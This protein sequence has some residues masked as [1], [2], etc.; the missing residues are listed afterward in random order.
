VREKSAERINLVLKFRL[1]GDDHIYIKGA[2]RLKVD[3][4]GGLMFHDVQSGKT[5]RIAVGELESFNILSLQTPSRDLSYPIVDH[6]F[7][8]SQHGAHS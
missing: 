7:Q 6:P 5:E 4:R 8:L 1:A 3:G 2:S